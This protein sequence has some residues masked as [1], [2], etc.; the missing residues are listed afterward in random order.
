MKEYEQFSNLKVVWDLPLI[1]RIDGRYFSNYTKKLR[2][3]KP[4]DERLR[5][6]FIEVSKDLVRE[7]S[8]KY[9]YTFSDEINILL[10]N[11]PFNGRVEKID[12]IF[13]SYTSAS[14]MKHLY[15]NL[16]Q[17][18]VD[19]SDI[20]V[21]SFDCRV[22][23]TASHINDYFKSRQDEAWRNCLN[24]Y[25]QSILRKEYSST[26]VAHKLYKLNK[27]QIHDLLYDHGINIAKVPTWQKR[28]L[29]VYKVKEQQEGFN[30]KIQEKNI[31]N[32][33]KIY[34]DM[35]VKLIR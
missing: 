12:S 21:A 16:D 25:A 33:N 23:T 7:F 15:S 20:D 24:G 35:E 22:I 2:L 18:S 6:L 1:L 8:P 19:T 28:G 14:F 26:D 5:D 27:S 13:A 10:D 3:E 4:F 31:S 9:V 32:K 11:I 30:P 34:V 17:F 29:A